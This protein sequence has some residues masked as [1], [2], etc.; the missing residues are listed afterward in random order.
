MSDSIFSFIKSYT[1]RQGR[2]PKEDYLT[3]LFAWIL[4]NIEG[5]SQEYCKYLINFINE[6]KFILNENDSIKITTQEI[7]DSGII[8]LLIRIND[9]YGFICEHKVNA[10]LSDGQIIKYNNSSKLLGTGHFYT[11]LITLTKLQ[12]TQNSD[13]SILWSDI[14]EW[15]ESIQIELSESNKFLLQ[16]FL[17]Y[18]KE[19]GLGVMENINNEDIIGYWSGKSLEK[20]LDRLFYEIENFDWRK[21]VSYLKEVNPNYYSIFNKNRWGRK[22]IDLFSTWKP[23]IF[24]GVILDESDHCLSPLDRLQGPDV[25]LLVE[26]QFEKKNLNVMENRNKILTSA[27]F[28]ELKRRLSINS[29]SFN[30]QPG[31]DASPWRVIVLRKSLYSIFKGKSTQKEQLQALIN[32]YIEGLQ[33]L[34]QNGL[35]N[36]LSN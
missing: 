5:L 31:I 34:T 23:G 22:G 2:N 16:Q 8:D 4:S 19:E 18:L 9:D 20:K 12:H 3:Q 30:Y 35:L 13:I 15:L 27:N 24:I 10:L 28:Q 26:L 32:T 6:Q 17:T 7:V 11:V 21:E 1:P 25:V 14:Y 29:G 36:N 33:L